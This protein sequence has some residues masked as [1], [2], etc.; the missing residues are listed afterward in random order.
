MI[1]PFVIQTN[2]QTSLEIVTPESNHS[3]QQ[4][5]IMSVNDYLTR[6]KGQSVWANSHRNEKYMLQQ[7]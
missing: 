5:E 6:L 1:V 4:C 3:I 2:P 7:Q